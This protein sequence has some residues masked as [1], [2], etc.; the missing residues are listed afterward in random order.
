[1]STPILQKTTVVVDAM[2]ILSLSLLLLGL[3][4]SGYAVSGQVTSCAAPPLPL[5][6]EYNAYPHVVR[7]LYTGRS[8]TM[9]CAEQIVDYSTPFAD[10]I[11][12]KNVA[13]YIVQQVYK[14]NMTVGSEI[15]VLFT[16]GGGI[17][18]PFINS[19]PPTEEILAFLRPNDAC[20]SDQ[21][22]LLTPYPSNL[23]GLRPY[24]MTECNAYNQFW[25]LVTA[26][27]KD[28]LITTSKPYCTGVW[29]WL[30]I[31]S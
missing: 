22:T 1:V 11:I 15:P 10:Q 9:A 27:T 30:M 12:T 18:T 20:Y 6:D 24:F 5:A 29:K 4:P 16:T 8:L 23:T 13:S 19:V 2:R 31:C 17:T 14:G 25:S 21:G 28:F 3:H 26:E 7:L